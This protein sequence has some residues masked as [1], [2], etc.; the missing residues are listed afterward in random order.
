MTYYEMIDPWEPEI[1]GVKDG[2]E[3][4]RVEKSGFKNETNYNTFIEMFVN[5][6]FLNPDK[7]SN[8]NFELECVK[9]RQGAKLTDVLRF[10]PKSFYLL[11]PN[12]VDILT[13]YQLTPHRYFQATIEDFIGRKIEG[14]KFFYLP[15]LDAENI[16]FNKC[17]F[18]VGNKYDG[19]KKVIINSADDMFSVNDF[20]KLKKISLINVPKNLDMLKVRL[21]AGILVSSELYKNLSQSNITGVK[22]HEIELEIGI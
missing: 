16:V 6:D 10:S 1:L 14:Y 5:Q 9:L 20:I 18:E 19:F 4:A 2:L 7:L 15:S 13:S 21:P 22:F 12:I 8:I 3:Q 11:S 17:Q